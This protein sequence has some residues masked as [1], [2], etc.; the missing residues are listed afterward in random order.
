[1]GFQRPR[2]MTLIEVI[3][4]VAIVGIVAFLALP[5]LE[6]YLAMQRAQTTWDI[7]RSLNF[8][9][10]NNNTALGNVG[11]VNQL[12]TSTNATAHYPA[13][14][15]QLVIAITTNDIRCGGP[16]TNKYT[17]TDV[18]NWT[19]AAPYSGLQITQLVGLSTPIG[20]IKDSVVQGTGT[21]AG[22]V[23]LR[24]D[25][26]RTT[27]AAN[28]DL[29]VDHTSDSTSGQV[30]YSPATNNPADL[31]MVKYLLPGYGC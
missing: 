22:Y 31:H 15:S 8:S 16:A 13:R 3:A 9:L 18:T 14:L 30:R 17:T 27:D 28:L 24:I 7:F 4:A 11:F 21:T 20:V 29:L 23:E 5:S 25:S 1:M 2:G 10:N 19:K 12:N 6:N 26:V